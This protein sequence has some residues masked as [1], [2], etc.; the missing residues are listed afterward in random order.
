MI[1]WNGNESPKPK[2]GELR[3]VIL[4]RD[5]NKYLTNWLAQLCVNLLLSQ[6]PVRTDHSDMDEGDEV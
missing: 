1:M 3:A 4:L 6:P 5:P 2:L